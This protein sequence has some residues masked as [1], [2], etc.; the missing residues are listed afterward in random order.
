MAR[1]FVITG[2]S[3]VGKGTLIR[4]LLSRVSGLELSVSATTRKPRPG[5]EDGVH[6]HFL[7]DEQFEE[8]VR[9]GAFVE[10]ADYSG[11]RYGTLRS[12]LERRTAGGVPVVL[13][14]EVQGARQ[15]RETLPDAVQV[16]IVPPSEEALRERLVGR[17]T[18]SSD[19]VERRLKVAEEELTARDEFQYQVVNDRLEDAVEEL[20]RIVQSEL[21]TG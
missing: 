15:V 7:T 18:D 3:G 8:R 10:H 11:R 2:P 21:P 6:Y 19:D 4:N 5:E 20:E 17:G 12:E 1:V 13:E 14:I 16:F 9:D